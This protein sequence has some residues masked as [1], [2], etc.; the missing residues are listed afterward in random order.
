MTHDQHGLHAVWGVLALCGPGS[1]RLEAAIHRIGIPN[2][3]L[4]NPRILTGDVRAVDE[5]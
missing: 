2:V 5:K 3:K 4:V 1:S